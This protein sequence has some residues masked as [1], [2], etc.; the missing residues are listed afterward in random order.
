M[1]YQRYDSLLIFLLPSHHGVAFASSCL[2]ICKYAHIVALKG[3]K[4]HLL[5]DVFVHLHLGRIVAVFRLIKSRV[6]R[7]I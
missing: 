2:T 7:R 5:P 6:K 4:Q 3:M 1:F